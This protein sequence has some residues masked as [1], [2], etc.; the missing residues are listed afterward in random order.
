MGVVIAFHWFKGGMAA[1]TTTSVKCQNFYFFAKP[2]NRDLFW[3]A[4]PPYGI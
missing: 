1:L 4:L 2:K 3:S